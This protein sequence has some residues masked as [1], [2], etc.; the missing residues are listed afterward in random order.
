M[1]G[2]AAGRPSPAPKITSDTPCSSMLWDN[3]SIYLQKNARRKMGKHLCVSPRC[4]T[5]AGRCRTEGSQEPAWLILKENTIPICTDFCE[6]KGKRAGPTAAGQYWAR[7]PSGDKASLSAPCWGAGAPSWLARV[8]SPVPE[9][10]C[11]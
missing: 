4:R 1:G 9:V 11:H 2:C 7:V 8:T 3:L 10:P 6:N 5:P